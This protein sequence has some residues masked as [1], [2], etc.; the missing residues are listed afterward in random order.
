M[1]I[2]ICGFQSSGKDTVGEFLVNNHGFKKLSFASVLKDVV[3]IMFGWSRTKLEGITQED[4]EWRETVDIWWSQNLKI[5]QL[6]PRFV[7]Q[8]FGT[9]L[10]RTH[11]NP[12]IWIIIIENQLTKLENEN[13][14]I[15]DCRFE[16]EI[17]LIL[18]YKGKI[19]HVFRN[20]PYWFQDYKKGIHIDEANK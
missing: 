13:I 10:F 17:N 11:W 18:K 19:I 5:P 3:S 9:E 16:N 20:L 15:T 6:T 12:D 2:G 14:V 1:I 7:L 8:Y 4:R